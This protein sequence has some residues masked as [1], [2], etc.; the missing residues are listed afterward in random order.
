[1]KFVIFPLKTVAT[2]QSHS[3][4]KEIV[5]EEQ[6]LIDPNTSGRSYS[7]RGL[8]GEKAATGKKL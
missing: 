7:T 8:Q 3:N 4:E 6:L 5:H 2:I 1:M